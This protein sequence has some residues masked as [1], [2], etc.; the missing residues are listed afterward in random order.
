MSSNEGP[1]TPNRQS[2]HRENKDDPYQ[3]PRVCAFA[4]A[5]E[6]CNQSNHK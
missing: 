1:G 6:H 5:L 3:P 2:A 4:P